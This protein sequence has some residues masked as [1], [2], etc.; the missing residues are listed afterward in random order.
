[1]ADVEMK[2]EDAKPAPPS[3]VSEIQSNIA[4]IERAVSTSETR[5]TH[6]VL[7]SFTAKHSLLSWL[8]AAPTAVDQSTDV[9][10]VPAPPPPPPKQAEPVPE[11]ELYLRLLI[12]HHLHTSPTTFAKS[13]DLANRIVEEMKALNRRSMDPIAAKVWYAVERTYDLAGELAEARP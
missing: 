8:P 3:P 1:M 11:V 4:L 12:L 13:K 6:R 2:S 9:D 7:R 10:H 5:F